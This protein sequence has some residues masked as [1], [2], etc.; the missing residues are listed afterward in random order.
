MKLGLQLYNFKAELQQDFKGTLREISRLGFDGVEFASRYGD[1]E[2][3][4]LA[5]YLKELNLEC[6]GTMFAKTAFSDME[7]PIWAMAKALNSPAVTFSYTADLPETWKTLL[8][9]CQT[10]GR[11]AAAHGMIFSYHNHWLEFSRLEDGETVMTKVLAQTDPRQVFMEPDVCW[12]ARSHEDP[13]AFIRKYASRIL[14]VHL[15]D[16]RIPEER[17]TMTALGQG[18][19]NL[20]ECIAAAQNSPCQWLIYEQDHSQD[21]FADAAAS[22]DFLK[23]NVFSK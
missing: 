6:A 11:N 4:E 19:V 5:A 16:L 13:A 3:A 7:S 10:A 9:M 17:E 22:L 23:R 1:M 12:L 20:V 2:P 14:Q 8:E 18:C 21:H 15:K